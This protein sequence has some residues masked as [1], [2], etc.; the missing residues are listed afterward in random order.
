MTRGHQHGKVLEN[1]QTLLPFPR[2][3]RISCHVHHSLLGV[4]ASGLVHPP[5]SPS[6][7]SLPTEPVGFSAPKFTWE[8]RINTV[9]TVVKPSGVSVSVFCEAQ[10]FPVPETR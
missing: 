8:E 5:P 6:M 2:L 4:L 9:L 3:Q 10:G 7:P 1:T